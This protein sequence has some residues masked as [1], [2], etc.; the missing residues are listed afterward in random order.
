[1]RR[2]FKHLLMAAL[3]TAG[4]ACL[5]ASAV[6]LWWPMGAGV[7]LR[8][9]D[10]GPPVHHAAAIEFN[11][12]RLRLGY[13]LSRGANTESDASA[14]SLRGAAGGGDANPLQGVGLVA[15]DRWF[16]L[17]W[18]SADPDAP[19][20][21]GSGPATGPGAGVG[22]TAPPGAGAVPGAEGLL[23]AAV[24]PGWLVGLAAVI[25]PMF[26][27]RGIVL[28]FRKVRV[29]SAQCLHCGQ[30]FREP[31]GEVC[32]NCGRPVPMVTVSQRDAE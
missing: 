8:H 9:P 31:V 10:W 24:L 16:A 22:T 3:L 28:G 32:P 4:L 25:L 27:V 6:S 21:E 26:W 11:A 7:L 2:L 30:R 20:G 13:T 29:R 14:F 19:A 17:R 18:G 5:T 23:M 15:A 12:G 1:M